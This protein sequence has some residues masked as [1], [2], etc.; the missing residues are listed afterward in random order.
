MSRTVSGRQAYPTWNSPP[1]GQRFAITR[2]AALRLRLA[3][4]AGARHCE[5]PSAEAS[6]PLASE[7]TPSRE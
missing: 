4:T 2:G 1:S 5:A 3:M 7:D 6:A